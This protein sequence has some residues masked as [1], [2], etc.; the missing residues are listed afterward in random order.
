MQIAALSLP[1]SA[2]RQVVCAAGRAGA[3]EDWRMISF[4]ERCQPLS[5]V[6]QE[7]DFWTQRQGH[8]NRRPYAHRDQ[9]DP[10]PV[11]QIPAHREFGVP[12]R[13]ANVERARA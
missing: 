9:E 10:K 5:L 6:R 3:G 7:R 2:A 8:R 13:I 12:S 1:V 4:Y 11:A